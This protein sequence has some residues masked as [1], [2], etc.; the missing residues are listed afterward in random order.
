M[1]AWKLKPADPELAKAK[2]TNTLVKEFLPQGGP[3]QCLFQ[4]FQQI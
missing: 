4:Q 3:W 1:N 2:A